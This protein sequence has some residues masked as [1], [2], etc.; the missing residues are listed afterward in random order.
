[1]AGGARAGHRPP[2][3][4][5]TPPRLPPSTSYEPGSGYTPSTAP[6]PPSG[7]LWLLQLPADWEPATV[8]T[9]DPTPGH[10]GG[11]LARGTDGAGGEWALF[12]EDPACVAGVVALGPGGAATPV[13]AS[14]TLVRVSAPP[15]PR[16]CRP[17]SAPKADKKLKKREKEG[18]KK[19]A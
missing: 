10:A 1:M 9:L 2:T 5:P 12:A 16:R 8:L 19:R 17:P 7:P 3:R 11:A 13:A 14:A 15:K 18:R 6:A 4:A